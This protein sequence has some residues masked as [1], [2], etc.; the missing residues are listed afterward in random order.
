MKSITDRKKVRFPVRAECDYCYNVIYNSVPLSLH[1]E[2]DSIKKLDIRALRLD[3][4]TENA[5]EAAALT[6]AF[7]MEKNLNSIISDFTKG[8]FKKGVE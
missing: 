2:L 4:T 7:I 1:K 8:H 5:K 3:F 6:E